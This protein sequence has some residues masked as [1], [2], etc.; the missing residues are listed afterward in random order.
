[1]VFDLAG[2]RRHKH[3][4][5]ANTGLFGFHRIAFISIGKTTGGGIKRTTCDNTICGSG[6]TIGNMRAD[7]G[8][9]RLAMARKFN[10]RLCIDITGRNGFRILGANP[11]STPHGANTRGRDISNGIGF[12]GN[13]F[14]GILR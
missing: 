9:L 11:F 6:D 10:I 4:R 1:M 14:G 8:R 5:L 2:R 7:T 12:C 3:R 13:L